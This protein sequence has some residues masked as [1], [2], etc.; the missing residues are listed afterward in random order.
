MTRVGEF[1]TNL[2]WKRR[3]EEVGEVEEVGRGWRGWE[4]CR[5]G[6][7][8]GGI[9]EGRWVTGN[10]PDR[11]GYCVDWKKKRGGKRLFTTTD[12]LLY[13]SLTC[14]DITDKPGFFPAW[15]LIVTLIQYL[16]LGQFMKHLIDFELLKCS[17]GFLPLNTNFP[18]STLL[19]ASSKT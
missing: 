13:S 1:I 7:G 8:R 4:G 9:G 18:S 17:V 14:V 11:L 12:T 5:G 16:H 15:G 3:E 6:V 2:T 10:L 19:L